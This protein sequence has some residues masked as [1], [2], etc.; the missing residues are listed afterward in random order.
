MKTELEIN[1]KYIKTLR[2]Q[3][4]QIHKPTHKPTQAET[5]TIIQNNLITSLSTHV[6]YILR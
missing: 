4:P 2:H 6:P 3:Q 5:D 1:D